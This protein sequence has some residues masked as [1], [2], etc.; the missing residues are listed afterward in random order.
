MSK[1]EFIEV[2]ENMTAEELLEL[3]ELLEVRLGLKE[4]DKEDEKNNS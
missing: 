3:K 2:I 4:S 1:E